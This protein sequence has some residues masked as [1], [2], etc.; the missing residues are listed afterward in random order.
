[1]GLDILQGVR[2]F[3]LTLMT[4]PVM[5]IVGLYFTARV[6]VVKNKAALLS[7]FRLSFHSLL[8]STT[9]STDLCPI[10][11]TCYVSV[12]EA[13]MLISSVQK[14]REG[15]PLEAVGPDC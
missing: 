10:L 15:C 5:K 9:M 14:G 1:M 7:E 12:S 3:G 4:S 6:A 8:Y 11:V 2:G 13:W